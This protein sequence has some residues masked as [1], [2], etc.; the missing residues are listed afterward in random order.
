[1]EYSSFAKA[2]CYPIFDLSGVGAVLQEN[3]D[4]DYLRLADLL[5]GTVPGIPEFYCY[6]CCCGLQEN[7]DM[8]YFS[9]DLVPIQERCAE[10]SDIRHCRHPIRWAGGSWALE[11]CCCSSCLRCLAKSC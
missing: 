6:C 3:C 5:L 9:L 10:R 4:M 8:E 7:C 1:M 2:S 11:G